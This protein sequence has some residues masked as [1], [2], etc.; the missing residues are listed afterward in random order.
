MKAEEN[1]IV[2]YVNPPI[3]GSQKLNAINAQQTIPP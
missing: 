3:C 1:E 2:Q